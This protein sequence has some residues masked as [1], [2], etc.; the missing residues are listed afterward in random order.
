MEFH[1]LMHKEPVYTLVHKWHHYSTA[2]SVLTTVSV[3]PV[4]SLVNGGFLNFAPVN[5]WVS[6]EKSDV[7]VIGKEPRSSFTADF[8]WV[9]NPE[10]GELWAAGFDAKGNSLARIPNSNQNA[11]QATVPEESGSSP[12]Q[13]H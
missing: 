9:F 7:V 4:E 13:P 8:G 2:P 5:L 11:S 12:S 3:N 1:R 6:G 10:T